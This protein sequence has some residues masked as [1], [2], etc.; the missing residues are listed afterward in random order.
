MYITGLFFV[1]SLFVCVDIAGGHIKITSGAALL[2]F[3][4]KKVHSCQEQWVALKISEETIR[5]MFRLTLDF[6]TNNLK[7]LLWELCQD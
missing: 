6:E 1:I 7:V 4:A 2:S 5:E 3:K